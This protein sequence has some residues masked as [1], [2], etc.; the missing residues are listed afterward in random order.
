MSVSLQTLSAAS[1]V[2]RPQAVSQ[3]PQAIIGFQIRTDLLI[4]LTESFS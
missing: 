4:V 1:G 3:I 2:S